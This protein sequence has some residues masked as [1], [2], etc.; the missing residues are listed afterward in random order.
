MENTIPTLL[1]FILSL[2]YT[3]YVPSSL[4]S[5]LTPQSPTTTTMKF[6]QTSC[7]K[8]TYP[9]L[10][11]TSLSSYAN[12]IQTS[13]QLLAHTALTVTLDSTR[14]STTM[15]SG[16]V[17]AHGLQQRDTSAVKDCM[18]QLRDSV[19]ELRQ[20]LAEMSQIKSSNFGLTMND[21]QTW[22]SAALTNEDTCT[23]GLGGE[24]MNVELR[25]VVREKV[26]NIAHLTS[27]ALALVN[28][29][30]SLHE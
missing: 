18:E 9:P 1:L 20:S 15:M 14:A 23:D 6:I 2:S 25:T 28:S 27:N 7:T 17:R 10:C 22:V 26:L 29:Y 16:L 4:A 3:S 21:I 11:I 8:T 13:P 30:A 12:A 24:S 5:R 19:E